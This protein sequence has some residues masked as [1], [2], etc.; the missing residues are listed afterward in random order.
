MRKYYIENPIPLNSANESEAPPLIGAYTSPLDILFRTA[1]SLIIAIFGVYLYLSPDP[2]SGPF[3]IVASAFGLLDW[4]IHELG[5]YLF[6]FLGEPITTLGGTLGQILFPLILAFYAFLTRRRTFWFLVFWIGENLI[7]IGRYMADA[8]GR[9]LNVI[10][11]FE[12]LSSLEEQK[13]K[14][15]WFVLFDKWGLLEYDH[16]LGD[17]VQHLGLIVI[18]LSAAGLATAFEIWLRNKLERR[19]YF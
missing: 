19:R 3:S 7:S 15:D 2:I 6:S 13:V 8:R 17:L 9:S 4:I 12:A 18:L 14:H 10:I 16:I 11:P 5:H 1:S